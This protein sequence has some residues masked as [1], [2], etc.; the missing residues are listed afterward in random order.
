MEQI[1]RIE[2]K[3]KTSFGYYK[4]IS[5]GHSKRETNLIREP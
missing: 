3:K 5:A 2:D 4:F 1:H